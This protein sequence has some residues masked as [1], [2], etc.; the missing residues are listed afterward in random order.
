MLEAGALGSAAA[1]DERDEDYKHICSL[2]LAQVASLYS[3]GAGARTRCSRLMVMIR[4]LTQGVEALQEI[5]LQ[6]GPR[7]LNVKCH[8]LVWLHPALPD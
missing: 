7:H 6:S 4:S 1:Q 8:A 2:S 5:G 3:L